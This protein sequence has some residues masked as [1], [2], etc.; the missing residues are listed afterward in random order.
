MHAV[1]RCS[2]NIRQYTSD[3]RNYAKETKRNLV[4]LVYVLQPIY[5]DDGDVY[6]HSGLGTSTVDAVY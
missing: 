3:T 1:C 6:S 5:V 2:G 4:L